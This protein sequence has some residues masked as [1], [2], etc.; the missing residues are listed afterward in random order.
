MR[1]HFVLPTSAKRGDTASV[2]AIFKRDNFVAMVF[3]S[4]KNAR[5]AARIVQIFLDCFVAL[6]IASC[7]SQ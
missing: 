1:V 4:V 6:A 7:A 5:F 3:V 2:K